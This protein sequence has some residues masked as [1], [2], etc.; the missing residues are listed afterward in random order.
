MYRESHDSI[1]ET[2][3]DSLRRRILPILLVCQANK[4]DL[5][6][7]NLWKDC[8][9]VRKKLFYAYYSGLFCRILYIIET[10]SLRRSFVRDCN[11]LLDKYNWYDIQEADLELFHTGDPYDCEV[12]DALDFLDG[13]DNVAWKISTFGND[14]DAVCFK[15]EHG[16]LTFADVRGY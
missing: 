9:D 5:S 15:M 4:G 14:R 6:A 11:L 13:I 7:Y 10:S 2:N 1:M 3:T 12:P 8:E 16:S